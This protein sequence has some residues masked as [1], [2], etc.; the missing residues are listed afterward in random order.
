[1]DDAFQTRLRHVKPR[2]RDALRRLDLPGRGRRMFASRAHPDGGL[3]AMMVSA[4]EFTSR[5][6]TRFVRVEWR[7]GPGR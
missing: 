3:V 5:T 4:N 1:M 2:P 6:L 7:D